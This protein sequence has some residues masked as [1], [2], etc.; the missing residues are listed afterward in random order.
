MPDE[1][2]DALDAIDRARDRLRCYL[3]QHQHSGPHKVEAPGRWAETL[4]KILEESEK[5]Y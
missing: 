1:I 2:A 5:L 3:G 4:T